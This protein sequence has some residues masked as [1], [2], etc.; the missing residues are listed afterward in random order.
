MHLLQDVLAFGAAPHSFLYYFVRFFVDIIFHNYLFVL[1]IHFMFFGF[2]HSFRLGAKGHL[3][4]MFRLNHEVKELLLKGF[5]LEWLRV[6]NETDE[7][8]WLVNNTVIILIRIWILITAIKHSLVIVILL[9]T[10]TRMLMWSF[11][12]LNL[13]ALMILNAYMNRRQVFLEV[14]LKTDWNILIKC[15]QIRTSLMQHS[16]KV[17]SVNNFAE[18]KLCFSYRLMRFCQIFMH[19]LLRIIFFFM[20]SW[21]KFG[22]HS[23]HFVFLICLNA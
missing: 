6:I 16:M 13:M 14:H 17:T 7:M 19:I 4:L 10:L 18:F 21:N 11:F 8:R 3:H 2:V 22:R 15:N 1:K 9:I 12:L 5:N 20:F 23:D